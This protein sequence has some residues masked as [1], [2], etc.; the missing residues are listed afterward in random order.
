MGVHASSLASHL[1]V[2]DGDLVA[3]FASLGIDHGLCVQRHASHALGEGLRVEVSQLALGD[4]KVPPLKP[5]QINNPQTNKHAQTSTHA[6]THARTQAQAKARI[7]GARATGQTRR[8]KLSCLVQFIL[9]TVSVAVILP[10]LTIHPSYRIRSRY[11][12]KCTRAR[13]SRAS[14]YRPCVRACVRLVLRCV[15]WTVRL[16]R[17]GCAR[18]MC[19]YAHP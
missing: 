13:D 1:G 6:R 4:Y 2:E 3:V 8:S 18:S 5:R 16:I 10:S 9:L 11:S 7:K 12:C 19:V 17:H 14:V 15:V